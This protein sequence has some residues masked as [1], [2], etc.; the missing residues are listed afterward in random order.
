MNHFHPALMVALLLAGCS[1]SPPPPAC[2]PS[3]ACGVAAK[4]E[5][6]KT[7][8]H[9]TDHVKY[10]AKRAEILAAC[11]DTPEFTQGEK[12]WIS[13]NLPEGEYQSAPEVISALHL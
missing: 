6:A 2:A 11:A 5:R 4:P 12:Q 1:N 9:L 13:D 8:A 3:A 7:T 10:P